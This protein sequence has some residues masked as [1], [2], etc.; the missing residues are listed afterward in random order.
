M[1]DER[2]TKRRLELRVKIARAGLNYLAI[3]FLTLA[4]VA[5]NLLGIDIELP[6]YLSIPY[7]SYLTGRDAAGNPEL[8]GAAILWFGLAVLFSAVYIWLILRSKKE[9]RIGGLL[10]LMLA[11]TVGNVGLILLAVAFTAPG[12]SIFTLVLNLAFHLFVLYFIENGRRAA[13]GLTV[14]PDEETEEDD[15]CADTDVSGEDE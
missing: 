8:F 4:N 11:D 9:N 10:A 12:A 5:L 14:L 1:A 2:I 13:Y 7:F 15:D 3:G 6:F